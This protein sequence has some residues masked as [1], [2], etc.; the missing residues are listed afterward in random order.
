ML[1]AFSSC[2][3]VDLYNNCRTLRL[4]RQQR[5]SGSLVPLTPVSLN[6]PANF[7]TANHSTGSSLEFTA[8]IYAKRASLP[9]VSNARLL[10]PAR[11][12]KSVSFLTHAQVS[13]GNVS[14]LSTILPPDVD[15]GSLKKASNPSQ[16]L[17]QVGNWNTADLAAVSTSSSPVNLPFWFVP[18]AQEP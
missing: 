16:D 4:F 3:D 8:D 17:A 14:I 9:Q 2:V 5:T 6:K 11:T 18:S 1:K 7:F 12:M 10:L 15:G 13:V